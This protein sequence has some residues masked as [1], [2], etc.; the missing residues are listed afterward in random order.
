M[1]TMK[2]VEITDKL[3]HL[4]GTVIDHSYLWD[5]CTR[6]VLVRYPWTR[7]GHGLRLPDG[8]L[9]YLDGLKTADL[10]G[11]IVHGKIDDGSMPRSLYLYI[12]SI[13]SHS[14]CRRQADERTRTNPIILCDSL[15]RG[16][17]GKKYHECTKV[18]TFLQN[19]V[20]KDKQALFKFI[21]VGCGKGY[22]STVLASQLGLSVFAVDKGTAQI[23]GITRRYEAIAKSG[24][25]D[26]L[27]RLKILKQ[28]VMMV[29]GL[30]NIIAA[31]DDNFLCSLHS[32]GDLSLKMAKTFLDNPS[33]KGMCNIGCCY[34]LIEEEKFPT[35]NYLRH[36]R[37]SL[38]RRARMLA[39]QNIYSWESSNAD[40]TF[41]LTVRKLAFRAILQ[42]LFLDFGIIET[43]GDV[44]KFA[45]GSINDRFFDTLS[46]YID[47][48]LT[49][50][51]ATE[52]GL[53]KYAIICNIR[54]NLSSICENYEL[55]H[56]ET[57]I[58][59]ISAFWTLRI[60]LS[61]ALE[62]IIQLDRYLYMLEQCK[63][64]GIE[65]ESHELAVVFDGSISA[66]NIALVAIKK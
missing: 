36:K 9:A 26:N 7:T 40:E 41:E 50:I 20:H 60:I 3:D 59:S 27:P 17:S 61:N 56:L 1:N 62:S 2:I 57:A 43:N 22:L 14:L 66:R 49:K 39:C 15:K 28:D 33:V 42:S 35:S 24:K 18:A 25:Y 47:Q 53:V 54:K 19:V 13:H 30:D 8:W 51:E 12:E 45:I 5:F 11:L 6:D 52:P 21:D 16:M 31:S 55:A 65:L 64:N 38:D 48:C 23:N 46:H 63:D 4:C 10:V 58:R 32:C 37:F 34:N 29:G 44:D